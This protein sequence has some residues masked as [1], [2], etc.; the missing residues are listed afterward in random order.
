MSNTDIDDTLRKIFVGGLD[1]E[2]SENTVREYFE[3]WGPLSECSIKRFPDGRSRGFAFVTFCSLAA[4]EQCIATGTHII[5][6][7]RVDLRRAASGREENEEILRA[8]EYDPEAKD[9][10]KLFVGNLDFETGEAEIE[11]YFSQ[12]GE[13]DNISMDELRM[14][15]LEA[16]PSSTTSPRPRWTES[17]RPGLT[18]CWTG[19]WRLSGPLPNIW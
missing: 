14:G 8:K 18:L 4:M 3:S 1:Y 6:G 11:A 19:S 13:I 7:K 17:R 5:D 10:K 16:T 12:Y 2:S 15:S 9:L